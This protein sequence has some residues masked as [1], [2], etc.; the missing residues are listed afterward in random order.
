[1]AAE[2]SSSSFKRPRKSDKLDKLPEYLRD[3]VEWFMG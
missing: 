2:A 3:T 1:M